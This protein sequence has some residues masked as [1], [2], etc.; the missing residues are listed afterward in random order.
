MNVNKTTTA[1]QIRYMP[2]DEFNLFLKENAG[3]TIRVVINK[4]TERIDCEL[5]VRQYYL[6]VSQKILA[7]SFGISQQAISKI[8]SKKTT[9]K[10]P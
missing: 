5:I 1:F 10:K 2:D 7:K 4:K 3:D 9:T 6:G 8:I